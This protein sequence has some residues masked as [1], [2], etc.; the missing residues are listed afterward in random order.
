MCES[1]LEL[2]FFIDV[3]SPR[4]PH[5]SSHAQIGAALQ[6]GEVTLIRIQKEAQG[7]HIQERFI[8]FGKI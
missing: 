6:V 1:D 5:E 7:L 8:F 2:P 4:F 3:Y